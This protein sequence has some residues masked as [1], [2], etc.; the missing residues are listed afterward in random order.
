MKKFVILMPEPINIKIDFNKDF[1]Y[2]SS[3]NMFLVEDKYG[4]L[5]WQN[6]VNLDKGEKNFFTQEEI[7]KFNAK[8]KGINLNVLKSDARE[9]ASLKKTIKEYFV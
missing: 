8:I 5:T 4:N 6:E 9:F 3:H 2:Q 1:M 7:N